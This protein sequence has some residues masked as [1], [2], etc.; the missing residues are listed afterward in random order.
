MPQM[1]RP[2]RRREL[3]ADETVHRGGIGDPQQR[4]GQAHQ[5][6]AFGRGQRIF[7]KECI[8]AAFAAPPLSRLGDE[9][10]RAPLDAPDRLGGQRRFG[11]N[12]RNR[13]LFLLAVSKTY[14][15]AR[16]V[17]GRKR[18]E[19]EAHGV[20]NLRTIRR[21]E[22]DV[23]G[24]LQRAKP[25]QADLAP[26]IMVKAAWFDRARAGDARLSG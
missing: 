1:A 22:R 21:P 7:M 19:D 2:I 24:S 3:V 10:A 8:D 15:L 18:S 17:G 11:Q 25:T 6:H 9:A 5:G 16:R 20:L 12:P 26:S 13:R 4:L 14:G 23:L